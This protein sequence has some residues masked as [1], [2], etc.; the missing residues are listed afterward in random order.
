MTT[1]CDNFCDNFCDCCGYDFSAGDVDGKVVAVHAGAEA[2]E[3]IQGDE[4]PA[5]GEPSTDQY[6]C[7]AC[8]ENDYGEPIKKTKN[9]F[10]YVCE[11]SEG[12]RGGP[13]W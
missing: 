5:C 6:W 11:H 1:D 3:C 9:G 4:C 2:G 13:R 12:R 7:R 10:L 8:L